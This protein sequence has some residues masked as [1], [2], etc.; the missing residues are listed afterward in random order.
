MK[1]Y[2]TAKIT[3]RLICRRKGHDWRSASQMYSDG[4]KR[5]CARCGKEE[6]VTR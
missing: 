2:M 4:W 1:G 3:E 5:R 6:N